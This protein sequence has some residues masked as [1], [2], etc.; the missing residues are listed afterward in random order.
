MT[1]GSEIAKKGRVKP[2]IAAGSKAE[3]LVW[4][5]RAAP[6]RQKD[7]QMGPHEAVIEGRKLSY[8]LAGKLAKEGLSVKDGA[9]ILVFAKAD[10]LGKLAE[11]VEV[12]RYP[13]IHVDSEDLIAVS[14]HHKDRPVGFGFVVLDRDPKHKEKGGNL[15]AAARPLIA[16]NDDVKK[17][18]SAVLD[19]VTD[20]THLKDW[21]TQ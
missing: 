8:S 10:D 11:P 2:G 21:G 7:K 3:R 5:L 4:R 19:E 1:P 20:T 16:D 15:I 6:A 17:M 12:F 14:N 9:V 13:S 18:L